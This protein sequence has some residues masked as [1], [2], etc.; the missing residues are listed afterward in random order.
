MV[1]KIVILILT[2]IFISSCIIY[3][4]GVFDEKL[5][6]KRQNY[7]GNELRLDGYYYLL[8]GNEIFG[9][10]IFYR[11]GVVLFGKGSAPN[12]E[13]FSFMENQFNR[14]QT[15]LRYQED[16]TNWGIFII[17]NNLI[18]IENWG[19][20]SGGPLK[21]YLKDGK[22]LNDTTFV[23]YNNSIEGEIDTVGTIYHFKQYSPKPDSTNRFI[24]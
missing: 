4:T 17:K 16:K 22:I 10:M 24:K 2:S 23:L 9:S 8:I 21:S 1:R 19:T 6:L 7:I 14:Y 12:Y 15:D 5:F 13:P 3:A 20:S 11:N 18:K